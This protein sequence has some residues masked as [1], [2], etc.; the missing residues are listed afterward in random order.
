[1][2][3]QWVK[4]ELKKDFLASSVENT[5]DYFKANRDK[6][7]AFAAVVFVALFIIYIMVNRFQKAAALADEQNGFTAIYLKS[8]DFDHAI[9]L[10]DQVLNTHPGGVQGGYANLYK[11]EA[12]YR[13]GNYDE[14]AKSYSAA[15]PLLKKVQ[16]MGAM[17]LFDIAMSYES[18]AKYDKA[19]AYYKQ[20]ADEYPAHYL[21][22]EAQVGQARCY[23]AAGNVKAAMVMYQNLASMN[24]DTSYKSLADFKMRG[25]STYPIQPAVQ[26][27]PAML[28]PKPA[29]APSAAVKKS[30]APVAAPAAKPAVPSKPPVK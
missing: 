3:R 4:E 13:K 16:D 24:P 27:Q 21:L 14:A 28:M 20:L 18:G 22:P 30:Q 29:V 26:Q 10:A 7:I 2:P 11:A 15:L 25:L 1:M 17:I 5:I 8:G 19:L 6:S 9:A 12:F 23:E